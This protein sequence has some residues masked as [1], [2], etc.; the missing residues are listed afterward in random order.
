MQYVELYFI[1]DIRH[2]SFS[3]FNF[4]NNTNFYFLD[5]VIILN[6]PLKKPKI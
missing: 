2:Y 3:V 6:D 1:F 4:N 5:F